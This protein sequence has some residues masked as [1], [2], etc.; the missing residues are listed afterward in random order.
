MH[1]VQQISHGSPSPPHHLSQGHRSP[2]RRLPGLAHRVQDLLGE[3]PG[4]EVAAGQQVAHQ[5]GGSPHPVHTRKPD[6]QRR[7][8][9]DGGRIL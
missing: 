9:L 7:G 8:R 4:L 2:R 5:A 3:D 6:V 1:D